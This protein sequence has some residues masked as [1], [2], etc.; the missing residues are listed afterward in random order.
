MDKEEIKVTTYQDK[1]AYVFISYS[2]K[3]AEEVFKKYLIPLQKQYGLRLFCD[4]DFKNE[5]SESWAKQMWK[6]MRKA[7]A[8]LMF[9][10]SSY[11]ESYACLLEVLNMAYENTKPLIIELQKPSDTRESE[12]LSIS[13][14]TRKMFQNIGIKLKNLSRTQLQK[15]ALNCY[16]DIEDEIEQGETSRET[17]SDLFGDLIAKIS[18]VT[19]KQD[20]GLEAIANSLEKYKVFE[21][22]ESGE[23][24]LAVQE[25][26]L[27]RE[28]KLAQAAVLPELDREIVKSSQ[29]I[30][31]DNN[32]DFWIRFREYIG[33]APLFPEANYR[34]PDKAPA[35][36]DSWIELKGVGIFKIELA[37][38][39][40]DAT[41]RCSIIIPPG[42]A[43]MYD[44][45]VL[46]RNE[47][48]KAAEGLHAVMEWDGKSDGK[49]IKFQTGMSE[50][51]RREDYEFFRKTAEMIYRIIVPFARE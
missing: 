44:R 7:S 23:D 20:N 50:T 8:C 19:L 9:V 42:K 16:V 48:E 10:S 15:D 29:P 39:I 14:S 49:R 28:D 17:V 46:H 13:P 31:T 21:K 24:K 25:D 37:I 30:L 33:D 38:R 6:N 32:L 3:D 27:A 26:T 5:A 11:V 51:D 36:H 43:A 40:K 35:T 12:L 47:I 45:I 2:S 18:V 34:V 4:V 22:T 41:I 1:K